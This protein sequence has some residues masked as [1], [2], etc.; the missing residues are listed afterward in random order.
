M[1]L[2]FS[3]SPMVPPSRGPATSPPTGAGS[4]IIFS[5]DGEGAGGLSQQSRWRGFEKGFDGGEGG[6]GHRGDDDLDLGDRPSLCKRKDFLDIEEEAKSHPNR[7]YYY[8]KDKDVD[9]IIDGCTK[10]LQVG[11]GSGDCMSSHHY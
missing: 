9:K 1:I 7:T 4:T 3:N 5:S 6:P 11:Q 8:R 2:G 10:K